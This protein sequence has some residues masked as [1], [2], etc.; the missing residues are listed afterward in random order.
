MKIEG[1]DHGGYDA[2]WTTLSGC[3]LQGE[4]YKETIQNIQEETTTF[5][6]ERLKARWGNQ[7]FRGYD[8]QIRAYGRMSPISTQVEA[9]EVVRAA[10]KI[11]FE[12]D[13]KKGS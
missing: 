12:L 7:D 9:K 11:G 8:Y 13:R 5:H 4:S 6:V 3:H 1:K 10:R 2:L